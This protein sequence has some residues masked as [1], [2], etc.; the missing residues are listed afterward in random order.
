MD[1]MS[2]PRTHLGGILAAIVWAMVLWSSHAAAKPREA[3]AA[4][5]L[6][7]RGDR[8]YLATPDSSALVPGQRLEIV[9]GRHAIAG[10]EI[11][12]RLDATIVVARIASGSLD[13]ARHLDRLV[14]R[15]GP[16]AAPQP[17]ARLRVGLPNA[18]SNPLFACASRLAIEP[19]GYRSDAAGVDR[20][21]RDRATT[22]AAPDT[23]ALVV[24]DDAADEE[25]ALER[26]EIDVAIFWPGERST[27][28]REDPRWRDA[29]LVPRRGVLA[30]RGPVGADT[31]ALARLNRQVFR[32]ELLPL[33]PRDAG[34]AGALYDVDARL[35]GHAALA[36]ALRS[37]PT[38][39]TTG[40]TIAIGYVDATADRLDPSAGWTALLAMRCAIVAAPALQ[41]SIR[42][43]GAMLAALT[44]CGVR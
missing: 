40:G 36:S 24:F 27:R 5:V 29:I 30:A 14:V 38:E 42:P 28:L 26:G 39:G 3:S 21:L 12:R 11:E 31:L 18:R 37:G 35:P 6:W 34:S 43:L 2:S 41:S 4:R 19:A 44:E 15:A 22:D 23:L 13:R 8:I 9:D 7:V 1:T 16:I 10:A 25:I 17:I 20:W 32:D 33:S